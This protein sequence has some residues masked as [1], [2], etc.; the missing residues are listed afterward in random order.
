MNRRD[1]FREYLGAYAD[2]ELDD[3]LREGVRKHVEACEACRRQLEAFERLDALFRAAG[4]PEV[5][6]AQWETVSQSLAEAPFDRLDARPVSMAAVR[7]HGRRNRSR[8][9]N[10]VPDGIGRPISS[11]R[12]VLPAAALLAAGVLVA[13]SLFVP[14]TPPS[15]PTA[16]VTD[17][18]VGPDYTFGV[19]LPLTDNDLLIIDVNRAE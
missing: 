3:V 11:S 1:E 12:W 10:G 7:E 2:G 6:E 17:I 19:T 16:E 4:A 18:E 5:S 8:T 15:T 9:L 13:L 14:A